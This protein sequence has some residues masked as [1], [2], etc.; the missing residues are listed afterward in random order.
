MFDVSIKLG[1]NTLR[2]TNALAKLPAAK[3]EEYQDDGVWHLTTDELHYNPLELR[4]E[5]GPIEELGEYLYQNNFENTRLN[6]L[7]AIIHDQPNDWLLENV[8]MQSIS[9]GELGDGKDEITLIINYK[10]LRIA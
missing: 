1:E 8:E 6:G 4:I 9:F 5:K 7:E 2:F 10:S 3:L